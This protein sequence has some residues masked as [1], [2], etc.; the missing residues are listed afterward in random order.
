MRRPA[1]MITLP[2]TSSRSSLLGLPTSSASSGVI[3][4]ALIP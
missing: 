3:V 4:A 2:P 1:R